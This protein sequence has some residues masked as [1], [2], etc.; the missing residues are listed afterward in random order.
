MLNI[1]GYKGNANQNHLK[2]PPNS[3]RMAIIKN[4]N[5]NKCWQG[6]EGKGTLIDCY[7]ECTLA[8][9][10]SKTVLRVLK[11]LK[12][13]LPY[14]PAISLLEIDQRNVSQVSIKAPACP[15]L[16]QCYSQ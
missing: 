7:W 9:P 4:T 3:F 10:L 5:N 6:C 11:K 13:E 8:Q 15:C 16:F 12:I 14:N 1:P 2:I